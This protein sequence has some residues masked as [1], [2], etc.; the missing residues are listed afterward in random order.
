[1][2][3]LLNLAQDPV[4]LDRLTEPRDQVLA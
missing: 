4:A 1:V 2:P 3:P